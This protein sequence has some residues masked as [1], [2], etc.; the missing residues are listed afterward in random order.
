LLIDLRPHS[1]KIYTVTQNPAID[2]QYTVE[3]ILPNEVLRARDCL[4]DLGGKGFNVSRSL[5][6]LG[7]SSV[8]IGFA[9]GLPGQQLVSGL[10]KLGIQTEIV[11]I[12]EE[13]R[14]NTVH[15]Q[16]QP[17]CLY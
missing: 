17:K 14:T 2:R 10:D 4:T 7:V 15:H 8:A 3:E 11:P 9:G 6:Q 1:D 16:L 5:M 13:T 12:A